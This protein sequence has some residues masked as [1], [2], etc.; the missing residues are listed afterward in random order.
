MAC[1][2]RCVVITPLASASKARI[3]SARGSYS[4]YSAPLFPY[5]CCF[6]QV[7]HLN[8]ITDGAYAGE[9]TAALR[10]MPAGLPELVL[11]YWSLD[12]PT[13][14]LFGDYSDKLG[15]HLRRVTLPHWPP[16]P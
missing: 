7:L 1:H 4:A 2:V 3:E 10:N 11:Q 16:L 13:H 8:M 6:A 5:V 9:V 15:Y 12:A 14:L